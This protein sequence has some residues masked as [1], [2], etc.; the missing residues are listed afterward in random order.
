VLLV[1]L[2]LAK[3]ELLAEQTRRL[4]AVEGSGCTEEELSSNPKFVAQLAKLGVSIPTKPSP[5]VKDSK[6]EPKRIP[7]VAKS[8]EALQ[9]LLL[10]PD[11]KVVALVE[12]RLAAK[13]TMSESRAARLI[14]R[15]K[16]GMKLPIYLGYAVAHTHRWAGGDKLN[17]QNF[18]QSH[19]V[20]GKL[21]QAIIAPPG[22]VIVKVDASQIEARFVAWLFDEEWV[23]DAF[24]DKRDI[25]CEFASDAY[26]RVITKADEQERFVGKTCV[27]GLGFGMGGPKLQVSLLTK[28]MEQGLDPVRL[29]LEVCF[30]LVNKYREKCQKVSKGWKWM[31]DKAIRAM[32]RGFDEKLKCVTFKKGRVELP[33]GLALLYPGITANGVEKDGGG[34]FK[35]GIVEAIQN[36]SYHG[37]RSRNKLYGGLLTENIVQALARIK[38]AEAMLEIAQRYRVVLMEHDAVG[39]LALKSEAKEALAY[40]IEVMST[41]PQWAPDIPLAAEGKYDVCYPK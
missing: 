2:P 24:R 13:S 21:K 23:L 26:E 33:N 32:L 19:K 6:G 5:T 37:A 40:G 34:W 29:P 41:S 9:A 30:H 25:Y 14:A 36:A 15:G 22:Y 35:G 12:G 4:Q 8:D 11:P 20:G 27:L 1:D 31:N 38:A 16:G 10:H 7:A 18:K 28:S 17:P 39:Y 3:S